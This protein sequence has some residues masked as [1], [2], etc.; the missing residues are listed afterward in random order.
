MV[1][2]T[3]LIFRNLMTNTIYYFFALTLLIRAVKIVIKQKT[4]SFINKINHKKR[5]R[6]KGLQYRFYNLKLDNNPKSIKSQ[7]FD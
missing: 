5:S 6:L 3:C 1:D 7:S 2:L 4:Q